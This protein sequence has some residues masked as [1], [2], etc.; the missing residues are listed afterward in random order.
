MVDEFMKVNLGKFWYVVG[1][2]GF[3]NWMVF[4]FLDV[5]DFGYWVVIFDDFR[6][7]YYE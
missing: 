4:F 6:D 7:V 1:V 5:N 2:M 3:I